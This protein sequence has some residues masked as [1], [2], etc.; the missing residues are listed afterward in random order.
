P[1]AAL[2]QNYSGG[3]SRHLQAFLALTELGI[4]VH[5]IRLLAAAA[6]NRVLSFEQQEADF[7]AEVRS[8]AQ[9]WQDIVFDRPRPFKN[10]A[11]AVTRLFFWPYTYQFPEL[12]SLLSVLQTAI[13]TFR[14]DFI[15]AEWVLCAALVSKCSLK[16][17]W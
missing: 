10:R 12:G 6:Q 4:E 17:P 9:S 2:S 16:L 1:N 7:Q 15:W 3:A 5:V 8:K 14:P 11:E 13:D